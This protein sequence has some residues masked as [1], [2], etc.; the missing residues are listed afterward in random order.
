MSAPLGAAEYA[1]IIGQ[2]KAWRQQSGL[3]QEVVAFRLKK[4]Q[5]FVAKYESGERNLGVAE[6]LLVLKALRKAPKDA[7]AEIYHAN[8]SFGPFAVRFRERPR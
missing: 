1:R 7:L 2:L 4:P 6:C 5:S 3:T 8:P